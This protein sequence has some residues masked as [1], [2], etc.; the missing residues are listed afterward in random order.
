[1]SSGLPTARIM[2]EAST[3]K[4]KAVVMLVDAVR[5]PAVDLLD[6]KRNGR[7]VIFV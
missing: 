2:I 5:G 1:M 6:P 4:N 7:H 3:G